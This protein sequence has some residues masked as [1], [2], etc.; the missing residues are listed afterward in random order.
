MKIMRKESTTTDNDNIMP[1][2]K[3]EFKSLNSD[4]IISKKEE[5]I[6]KRI[7]NM[8][9]YVEAAKLVVSGLEKKGIVSKI[10][11]SSPPCY[12]KSCLIY[13]ISHQLKK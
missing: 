12:C 4:E 3:T 2:E 10:H 5:I 6:T 11:S 1:H 8:N 7:Q 13:E 9:V